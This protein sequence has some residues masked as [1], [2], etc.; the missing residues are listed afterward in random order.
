MYYRTVFRPTSVS[1]YIYSFP[2]NY[3]TRYQRRWGLDVFLLL[4]CCTYRDLSAPSQW[5]DPAAQRQ[6]E[7]TRRP[8]ATV[9][10]VD[11][12]RENDMSDEIPSEIEM[13]PLLHS[14]QASAEP[15]LFP[16]TQRSNNRGGDVE[17][18]A[19]SLDS[20]IAR[21]SSTVYMQVI[22]QPNNSIFLGQY[23]KK[24]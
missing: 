7:N 22:R 20:H 21:R 23:N 18:G 5:A 19:R 17:M 12:K 16:P 14:S 15:P 6:V 8:V 24:G 9:E 11:T 3:F 13:T 2:V 4:F 1:P 10:V